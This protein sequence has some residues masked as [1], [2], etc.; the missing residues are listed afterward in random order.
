VQL[1]H[2]PRTPQLAAS[3]TGFLL[4]MSQDTHES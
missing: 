1:E 3:Y 4:G 2:R